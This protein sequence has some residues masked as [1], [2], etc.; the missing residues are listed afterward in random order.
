MNRVSSLAPVFHE[1]FGAFEFFRRLGYTSEEITVVAEKNR[2][3]VCVTEE[4][5][6]FFLKI[7]EH[8]LSAE[9]F[10]SQWNSACDMWNLQLQDSEAR[11]VLS[12]SHVFE[13]SVPIL[14]SMVARGF[15]RW[16]QRPTILH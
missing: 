6:N 3:Y 4:G 10:S 16:K 12:Q 15:G 1:V 7:G 8:N 2:V 11:E 9:E 13:L 14:Q 5:K